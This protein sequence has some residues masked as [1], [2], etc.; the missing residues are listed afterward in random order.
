MAGPTTGKPSEVAG[1]SVVGVAD[2]SLA[3]RHGGISPGM[4]LVE[5][6]RERVTG[7]GQ[8]ETMRF[9][10]KLAS[11][12]RMLTLARIATPP[13]LLPPAVSPSPSDTDMRLGEA[14]SKPMEMKPQVQGYSSAVSISSTE[15]DDSRQSTPSTATVGW[16]SSR[17]SSHA[18]SPP[19]SS[20]LSSD[21]D[22]GDGSSAVVN[23]SATLSP[24]QTSIDGLHGSAVASTLSSS[25]NRN[26]PHR[27]SLSLP[28]QRLIALRFVGSRGDTTLFD[29]DHVLGL[30]TRDIEFVP[31]NPTGFA[32]S[33]SSK[34]A[35]QHHRVNSQRSLQDM[36]RDW[37]NDPFSTPARRRRLIND[38]C[39]VIVR[40]YTHASVLRVVELRREERYVTR[41]QA[42]FRMRSARRLFCAKL[43]ARRVNA[44]LVLQLGWLSCAARRQVRVLRETRDHDR[45]VEEGRRKRREDHERRER[46]RRREEQG[47]RER[48]ATE[49]R[50]RELD[51]AVVLQ[52]RFR[53]RQEVSGM[54]ARSKL[55]STT[56]EPRLHVVEAVLCC[57]AR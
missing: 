54:R 24:S 39:K 52:R 31:Q 27:A 56:T 53:A 16:H 8:D 46:S 21:N 48:K 23:G 37:R 22:D 9:M 3:A 2:G 14:S 19:H 20:V 32:G 7:M 47:E 10:Q 42:A 51:L 57:G 44:A 41:I 6:N 55:R 30:K 13:P 15:E 26:Q 43:E 12:P 5:I 18:S 28:P 11:Q 38:V 40:T 50:Q 34:A 35:A 45:R 49:K 4:M 29:R 33:R 1:L 17:V 25:S 36:T